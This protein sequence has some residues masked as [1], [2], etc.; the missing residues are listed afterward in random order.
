M[1]RSSK[2][3]ITA[4]N[5]QKNREAENSKKILNPKIFKKILQPEILA[6]KK[7]SEAGNSHEKFWSRKFSHK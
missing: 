7:N 1:G 5:S 2:A 6:K 3:Q 4:K